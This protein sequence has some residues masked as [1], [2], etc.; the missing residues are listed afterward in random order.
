QKKVL[1]VSG[2]ESLEHI[3]LRAE[4][5]NLAKDNLLLMCETNI[6]Q[7]ASYMVEH[8][9]EVVVRD[10]IHTMYNPEIQSMDGGVTQVRE[11]SA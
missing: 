2:E 10:S 5:L 4:R 6:E 7:I 1:Y 9:P 3:A 8:K 11:S